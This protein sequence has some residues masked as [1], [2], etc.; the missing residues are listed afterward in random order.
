MSKSTFWVPAAAGLAAGIVVTR[1]AHRAPSSPLWAKP[2][3][4]T[5]L[6]TADLPVGGTVAL[7]AAGLLKIAGRHGAAVATAGLALGAA[8]GALGT[9]I[10]EPLPR[11]PPSDRD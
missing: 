5:R 2:L 10:A 6:R 9:G 8:L 7:V 3:P 1:H 11:N 4:G